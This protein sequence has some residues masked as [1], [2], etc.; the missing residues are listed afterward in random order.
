MTAVHRLGS[1]PFARLVP[2]LLVAGAWFIAAVLWGVTDT[3]PGGRWLVVHVFTL[4]VLTNLLIAFSQ[5][6]ARSITKAAESLD[7]RYLLVLNASVLCV[8]AGI[9]SGSRIALG[10]GATGVLAVVLSARG[11]LAKMRRGAPSTRFDWVVRTYEQGHLALTLGALLGAAL[12]AGLVPGTWYASARIAH[13]HLN[14]FGWVGLIVLATVLFFAPAMLRVRIP[15]G[16]E[17]RAAR[18]LRVGSVGLFLACLALLLPATTGT[19]G[20]LLLLGAAAGLLLYTWPVL[21]IALS[22][23]RMAAAAH[24]GAA[25]ILV[26]AALGWFVLVVGADVVAVLSGNLG[27]LTPLGLAVGTGVL[28]QLILAVVLF[29]I[30]S[31]RGRDLASRA[32]LVARAERG[33]ITRAMI[34]NTAVLTLVVAPALPQL[35]GTTTAAAWTALLAV[36]AHALLL[37][38]WP[39]RSDPAPARQLGPKV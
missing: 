13:L 7:R 21:S 25:R 4:G 15:E 6:F 3:L 10:I 5:H 32:A 17:E 29:L 27:L 9:V 37:A 38:A 18:S 11:R 2:A 33:G 8:L 28:L 31:L 34:L 36:L 23:L 20:Q 35:R 16:V 24:P 30:P 14:I 22:V 26:P 1:G 19:A 39:I 12:G